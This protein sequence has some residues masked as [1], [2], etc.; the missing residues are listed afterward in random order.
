M[1]RRPSVRELIAL[2]EA[3]GCRMM[4]IRG[5]H[6]TFVTPGGRRVT[7]KANRPGEDCSMTVLS[8]VRRALRK[9]GIELW[10]GQGPS[11]ERFRRTL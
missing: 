10:D 2:I 5:S 9:E 4:R 1:S 7:L 6:A 3:R 8:A 11:R